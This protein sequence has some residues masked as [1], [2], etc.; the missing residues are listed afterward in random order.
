MAAALAWGLAQ[1]APPLVAAAVLVV[2]L[3]AFSGCL[4]LDGLSDTADGFL[5]SRAGSGSWRS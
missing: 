4:H 1:V 3:M 2:V 5:S